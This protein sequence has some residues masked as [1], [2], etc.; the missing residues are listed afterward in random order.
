MSSSVPQTD[1]RPIATSVSIDAANL[2]VSLVDG[3]RL[4]VPL[5]WFPWLATANRED[6][7]DHRLVE[8]GQGIWWD[9]LDEGLSVAALFGLGH[10]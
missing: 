10:G 8:D 1:R 7:L 5:S 9:R 2:T 6:Q 4:V 3:R